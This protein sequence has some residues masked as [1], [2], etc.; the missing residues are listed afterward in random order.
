MPTGSET[1]A[2]FSLPP[3][4]PPPFFLSRVRRGPLEDEQVAGATRERRASRERRGRNADRYSGGD[5]TRAPKPRPNWN[6]IPRAALAALSLLLQLARAPRRGII[7]ELAETRSGGCRRG[8]SSLYFLPKAFPRV[9]PY[10]DRFAPTAAA[11]REQSGRAA[12]I[13]TCYMPLQLAI[14]YVTA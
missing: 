6:F 12:C 5:A 11:R 4:P 3:S 8:I 9:A 1:R 2:R 7:E 10:R 14:S 13:K